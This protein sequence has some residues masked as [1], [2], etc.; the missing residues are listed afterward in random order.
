MGQRSVTSTQTGL[1]D[2]VQTWTVTSQIIIVLPAADGGETIGC[3]GVIPKKTAPD[4]LHRAA[5]ANPQVKWQDRLFILP[6]YGI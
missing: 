2:F 1:N 6:V 5:T 4:V 3:E